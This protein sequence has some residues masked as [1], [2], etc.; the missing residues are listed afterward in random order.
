MRVACRCVQ[1]FRRFEPAARWYLAYTF[2]SGLAFG[3]FGLF[4]NLY[5]LAL[6][7]SRST[8]GVL[9]AIPLL[10]VCALALP[11]GIFGRRIGYRR[12][13]LAGLAACTAAIAGI[14]CLPSRSWLFAF[15]AG[16]GL[17]HAF[18]DVC[19]APLV[20]EIS[21]EA[22]RTHLFSTQFAVRLFAS[23]FGSL[24]AGSMP[25]TFARVFSVGAE[26]PAAYRGTLLLGA[27]LLAAS[28]FPLLRVQSLA[29]RTPSVP[30]SSPPL[31]LPWRGL[32]RLFLPQIV[33][34]IGAGAIV[35]FLNVFL[36]TKFA[37][38]DSALGI[39][40]ALQA[41][42]MGA[43]TLLGPALAAR[44]GRIRALVLT[45][46]ASIP[47]LAL[48]GFSPLFPLVAVA[49]L[50]RAGL[51]NMGHPLYS[52]FAME[53]VDVRHRATASALLVMSSQGSRALSSWWSGL[54]QEGPGFGPAFG[55]TMACYLA[56][57]AL[58]LGFFGRRTVR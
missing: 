50:A 32:S 1:P 53:A 36:K 16:L 42:A 7:H 27:A 49:F 55:L 58:V 39:L 14:A 28:V 8:L 33:I 31:P 20:A 51:M 38:S 23:F 40:F 13:L 41:V 6:G 56:A 34:G 11:A 19:H 43:A 17:G 9:L 47:F 2:L 12:A 57:S 4:Y 37:L 46:I 3:V 15:A 21:H 35:P 54:L 29:A 18:L 22:D 26:S 5:V 52:A 45:Q 44:V 24:V 10:V 25:A 48:L 30:T